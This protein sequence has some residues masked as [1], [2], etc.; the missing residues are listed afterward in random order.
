M[1][2]GI[3]IPFV[4]AILGLL[5]QLAC[6]LFAMALIVLRIVRRPPRIERRTTRPGAISMVGT[7]LPILA[8]TATSWPQLVRPLLQGDSLAY[9]LPNA[10]AWSGTHSLWTSGTWYWWY[11]GASELFAAGLLTVAGPL[12]VG[13]A[14]FVAVL[15]LANRLF[16]FSE[17]AGYGD[18]TSGAFAAAVVT[19]STI[20]LQAG[21]LEND[22]WLAAFVLEMVWAMSTDRWAA[23]RA[24]AVTTL[25]KPYGFVFA[26][27]A[28]LQNRTSGTQRLAVACFPF[29]FWIVRDT[30]LWPNATIPPSAVS[31]PPVVQTMI[32]GHGLAGL[33][34]LADALRHAGPGVSIA[35]VALV[36]TIVFSCEPVLR[37]TACGTLAF[38]LLQPYGFSNDVPQLATG[39]SLRYADT[40]LVLG[41]VGALPLLRRVAFPATI[42]FST[43]ACVQ[44][45]TIE[46]VFRADTT[47]YSWFYV[48]I[49]IAIAIAVDMLWSR[50]FVTATAGASLVAYAVVLAGSHP[51]DYYND[52]SSHG[53]KRSAFYTWLAASEPHEVISDS[54]PLG[55]IVVVSPSTLVENAA[56][57]FDCARARRVDAVIVSERNSRQSAAAAAAEATVGTTCGS[58]IYRDAEFTVVRPG[59]AP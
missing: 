6:A 43:L 17:R 4:L 59:P 25:I 47:T 7:S 35:S 57:P 58:V 14:G 12:C 20:A 53:S 22:V 46:N 13:F 30:L 28:A 42:V 48:T 16:A 3:A 27:L 32:A 50:G 56:F 36:A 8:V 55:T 5:T 51:I 39:A 33:Q 29:A 38:F 52:A 49:G 37:W 31:G 10:A 40:A 45:I 23:E 54:A 41:C 19:L 21:S 2:L 24:I 9:H 26:V 1:T 18:L 34:T 44:V 11:P 15:L